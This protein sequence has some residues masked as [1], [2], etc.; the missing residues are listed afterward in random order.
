MRAHPPTTRPAE[1]ARMVDTVH[2]AGTRKWT[3]E[4]WLTSS[5]QS[6][7]AAQWEKWLKTKMQSWETGAWDK[8][9]YK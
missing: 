1:G 2:Y 5:M 4:K 7:D 3:W 6:W 9:G 8:M